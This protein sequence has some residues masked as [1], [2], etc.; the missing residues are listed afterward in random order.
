ME[1]LF[2]KPF[3]LSI[4]DIDKFKGKEIIKKEA[5]AKNTCLIG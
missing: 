5:F 1:E 3:T 4:D 2:L